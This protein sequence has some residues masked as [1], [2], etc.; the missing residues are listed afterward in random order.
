MLFAMHLAESLMSSCP[1]YTAADWSALRC[2]LRSKWFPRVWVVQELGL[3]RQA[4][5]HYGPVSFDM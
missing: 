3:A 4:I 5:F 1:E 2:I